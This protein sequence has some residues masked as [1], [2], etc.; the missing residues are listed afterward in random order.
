MGACW[1][2]FAAETRNR[3]VVEI[4]ASHYLFIDR[5]VEVLAAVRAF[6]SRC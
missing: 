3:W 6:L 2:R 1:K 5:R 4:Q